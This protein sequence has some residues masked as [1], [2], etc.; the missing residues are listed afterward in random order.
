MRFNKNYRKGTWSYENQDKVDV[1]V[2]MFLK[3]ATTAEAVRATGAPQTTARG[4]KARVSV[5]LNKGRA[6]KIK[7]KLPDSLGMWVVA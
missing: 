7:A 3:G 6:A 5:Y 4:I 2:G 1:L